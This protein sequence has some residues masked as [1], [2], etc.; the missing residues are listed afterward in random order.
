MRGVQPDLFGEF[1]AE[2][3]RAEQLLRFREAQQRPQTC[4]A[5]GVTEPNGFLLTNNHGAR[6]DPETLTVQGIPRP[7]G[8]CTAQWLVRNHITY[9]AQRDDVDQLERDA[10]RGR[11]LGLDVDAIVAAARRDEGPAQ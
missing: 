9:S 10:A 6:L 8:L 11:E 2:Q 1:D 7:D 4:P 5:C 3:E